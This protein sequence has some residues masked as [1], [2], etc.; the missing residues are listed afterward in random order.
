MLVLFETA[1]GFA[2]FKVLDEG[3]LKDVKAL[4]KSFATPASAQKMYV[5]EITDYMSKSLDLCNVATAHI[6]PMICNYN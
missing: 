3:K 5:V 6:A 1:A 2:L 4:S